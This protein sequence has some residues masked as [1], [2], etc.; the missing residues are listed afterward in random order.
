VKKKVKSA[1]AARD[2]TRMSREVG[3]GVPEESSLLTLV[4]EAEARGA[5][6]LVLIQDDQVALTPEAIHLALRVADARR[7]DLVTCRQVDGI[8]PTV[9][10]VTALKR[11]LTDRSDLRLSE[12]LT[13]SIGVD[14]EIVDLDL[15]DAGELPGVTRCRPVNPRE[16][17]LIGYW[18]THAARLSE[19]LRGDPTT[20]RAARDALR[21]LLADYRSAIAASLPMYHVHGSIGDVQD[22]RRQ[23]E[24]THKPLLDYFVIAT[25]YGRFLQEFAGLRQNSHVLDIGC[26][27]GYLGF[28]LANLL[29][30]E[31][32]YLG[33]EVQ[34]PAVEWASTRLS[35][36]GEN[37][38][39]AHLDLQNDFYNPAGSTPRGQVRLPVPDEWSDVIVGGSVFTHM[40]PDGIA[41]YLAEFRR[42]LR[43]NGVAAFS[44]L[45][46]SSFWEGEDALFVHPDQRDKVTVYSRTRIEAMLS[47]A[48]LVASREPVNMRQ[49]DRSDYQT[50]Y[51]ARRA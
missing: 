18:Q 20:R 33:I 49:Y 29:S 30:K 34:K 31:G 22:V 40:Q 7:A 27:W 13:G 23:M 15:V 39:F 50:W 42:I 6:R 46:S 21:A 51:F 36:L 14:G 10:E 44:Y 48:Q 28:A 38:A 45:D 47:E 25:H 9:V 11:W 37:F 1:L 17:L 5:V 2:V 26:S 4:R 41:G 35:W 12:V 32:A 19:A 43:R 24:I 3:A 8:L 16:R